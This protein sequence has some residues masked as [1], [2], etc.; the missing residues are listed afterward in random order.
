MGKRLQERD[1]LYSLVKIPGIGRKSIWKIYEQFGSF[2]TPF[3]HGRIEWATEKKSRVIPIDEE[4]VWNDKQEAEERGV[5]FFTLWDDVYP[6]YLREIPDPPL[7]LFYKGNLSCLQNP[8]ISVVGS[9]IPST[10]GKNACQVLT[11]KLASMGM[12]IVSGFAK[13]IDTEAHRAALK[14]EGSTIG[15]FGSGLDQIYPA[16]NRLLYSHIQEN[17][18]L[19]SEYVPSTL[20][21]PG[22]FPERNRI[23]SGLSWATLVIEAAIKSGSLI[24]AQF[25]LEQG[26]DVFAVPGSIFSIKSEGTNNLIKEGAK[27]VVSIEDILEELPVYMRSV[28][29]KSEEGHAVTLSLEEKCL[30]DLFSDESM[31]FDELYRLMPEKW[32]KELP[33]LL[34]QLMGKDIIVTLP[35]NLYERK[36]SVSGNK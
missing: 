23:I 29:K 3:K 30:F 8:S 28:L 19:L 26:R 34:L 7:L 13:G 21:R 1:Y 15:V 10:Y 5:S 27:L 24:T 35:G 22:F 16:E 6:S 11:G 17:G 9:R 20:P 31:H 4:Q 25:A 36:Q 2:E 32:K 14:T 12:T 18:L 33:I